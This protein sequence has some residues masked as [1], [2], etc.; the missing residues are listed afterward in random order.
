MPP[1]HLPRFSPEPWLAKTQS[2]SWRVKMSSTAT[3]WPVEVL[4]RTCASRGLCW[5]QRTLPGDGDPWALVPQGKGC[6]TLP[7]PAPHDL[8]SS[9]AGESGA[10]GF[11]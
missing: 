7:P 5:R 11:R 2:T 10:L 4:L 8:R 3:A 9:W 1:S 6:D